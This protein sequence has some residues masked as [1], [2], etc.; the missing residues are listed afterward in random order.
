MGGAK[1]GVAEPLF[2][3]LFLLFLLFLVY[4]Y[5]PYEMNEPVMTLS[6]VIRY[7]NNSESRLSHTSLLDTAV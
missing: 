7:A 6:R 4:M 2:L 5:E 1:I 3:L